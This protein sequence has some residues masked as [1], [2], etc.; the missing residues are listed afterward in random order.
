MHMRLPIWASFPFI[1]AIKRHIRALGRPPGSYRTD[2]AITGEMAR[3]LSLTV[4]ELYS[5]AAREAETPGL[6]LDKRLKSVGLRKDELAKD[7][8]DVLRDLQRVCGG[9]TSA[10]TCVKDFARTNGAADVPRYCPN[11][12]TLQALV[13]EDS[14]RE[15]S[16]ARPL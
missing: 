16:G 5:L 7:H 3:D 9:C 11:E 10:A 14:L 13:Q 2:P 1:K 6:L 12:Q 4:S 15:K 8:P